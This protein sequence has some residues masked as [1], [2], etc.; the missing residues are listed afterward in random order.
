MASLPSNLS[1]ARG[2]GWR[3]LFLN[4]ENSVLNHTNTFAWVDHHTLFHSCI[5]AVVTRPTPSC[6]LTQFRCDD[7]SCI[8]RT[9]RCDR[10]YDCPDGS[11]ESNC[12][13][14][15]F[16]LG[17]FVWLFVT[18]HVFSWLNYVVFCILV[19]CLHN[20]Y[21]CAVN[22]AIFKLRYMKSYC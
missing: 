17:D 3:L 4:S 18:L 22:C 2:P 8:D 11:D 12:S 19:V 6:A 16:Y 9:L 15:D 1:W 20:N 10:K 5:P 14:S 13:M 21:D 7:Q